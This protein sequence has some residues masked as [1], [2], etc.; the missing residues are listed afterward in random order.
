M[1]KPYKRPSLL[2]DSS[3]KTLKNAVGKGIAVRDQAVPNICV[4]ELM[5][6]EED[7]NSPFAMVKLVR[8][9]LYRSI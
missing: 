6:E 9:L 8:W 3:E 1:V 4:L 2:A 7:G 5:I